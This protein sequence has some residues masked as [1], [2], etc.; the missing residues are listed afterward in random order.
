MAHLFIRSHVLLQTYNTGECI[1]KRVIDYKEIF[2]GM[3]RPAPHST[4]TPN[5][6]IVVLAYWNN[7]P[8]WDLSLHRD[9]L[10]R[11]WAKTSLKISKG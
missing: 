11:L 8:Q 9:T 1:C 10:T 7:N 6:I 4:N 3:T 2:Y 5:R